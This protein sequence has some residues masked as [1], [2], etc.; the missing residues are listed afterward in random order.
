MSRP[1]QVTREAGR[2]RPNGKG[3]GEEGVLSDV[4]PVFIL[5]GFNVSVSP[6]V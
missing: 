4:V 5:P 3:T 1:D 2:V 6:G